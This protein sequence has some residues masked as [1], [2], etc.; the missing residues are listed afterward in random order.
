[1]T[2]ARQTKGSTSSESSAF[3]S[4]GVGEAEDGPVTAVWVGVSKRSPQKGGRK[5]ELEDG[6]LISRHRQ[7]KCRERAQNALHA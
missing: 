7:Q 2:L 4:H 5:P 1:M 3:A 6:A